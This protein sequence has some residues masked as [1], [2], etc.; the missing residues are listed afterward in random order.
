[1]EN[2]KA[3]E[4]KSIEILKTIFDQLGIIAGLSIGEPRAKG[5]TIMIDTKEPGRLIGRG[6]VYLDSLQQV[7]NRILKKQA[8]NSE[9]EVAYVYLV[10]SSER[11]PKQDDGQ[12]EGGVKRRSS[13]PS[14]RHSDSDLEKIKMAAI[15]RAKEVK[16]WGKPMSIGPYNSAQ[17]R[18][19]HIALREDPMVETESQETENPALK[20]VVIKPVEAE[21]TQE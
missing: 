1:M 14:R 6:G 17:R 10:I 18:A 21:A 16:R 5:Y 8:V 13:T 15:D 19:V 7:V 12:E 4:E 9:E 3:L 2:N 11:P 20:L